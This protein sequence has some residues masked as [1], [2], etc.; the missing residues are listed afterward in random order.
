M[1]DEA[2]APAPLPDA[3][4]DV[5]GAVL[6]GVVV[7]Q[8]PRVVKEAARYAKALGAPLLVVNVDVTRFVAYEDPDGS[9]QTAAIDLAA[10]GRENEVRQITAE[11]TAA[12]EGCGVPWSTRWLV[13]DP[14]LA[15]KKLA[16]EVR[17]RLIVIGTRKQGLGE[18]IRE[19]FTGSVAVRL[20]HRQT[21]PVL[22]VPI[23]QLLDDDQDFDW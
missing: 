13:G 15:M 23:G 22:V 21:R 12:L 2:S 19:F 10:V 3:H 1:S 18:S 17:A 11:A 7:D 20:A 5:T 8:S 9:V 6:V 4:G 16:D 14:A